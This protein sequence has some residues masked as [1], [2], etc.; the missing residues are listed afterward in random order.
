MLELESQSPCCCS[1]NTTGNYDTANGSVALSRNTTGN[2]NTAIGTNAL[3]NNAIG[4]NNTAVGVNALK[5]HR[6]VEDQGATITQQRKDFEAAI[7][8]QQKQIEALP[9]NGE[10]AGD[11]RIRSGPT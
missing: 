10:T 4:S 2:F 11:S 5:E 9:R 8:Q 7:A 6:T 1:P 3:N